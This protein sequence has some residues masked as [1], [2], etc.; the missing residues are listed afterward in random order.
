MKPWSDQISWVT[1]I[2]ISGISAWWALALDVLLGT[3]CAG[4]VA[5]YAMIPKNKLKLHNR[6]GWLLGVLVCVHIAAILASH[7]G[8]MDQSAVWQLGYGTLAR[9][10]GVATAWLIVVVL[11]TSGLKKNIPRKWW[12]RAHALTAPMLVFGTIHGLKA[13]PDQSELWVLLPGV[14][15]LTFMVAVVGTRLSK[16]YAKVRGN[17]RSRGVA[18]AVMTRPHGLHYRVVHPEVNTRSTPRKKVT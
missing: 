5:R 13:G 4:D 10:T 18:L 11:A 14:V 1:A 12:R 6:L 15:V 8:G 2:R 3:I 17:Y 7:F 9:N 16:S